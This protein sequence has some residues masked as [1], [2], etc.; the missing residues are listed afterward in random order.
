M[1]IPMLAGRD[2]DD[3]DS[4][5]RAGRRHQPQDREETL[6][7]RDPIGRQIIFGTENGIGFAAEVIGVVGDVRSQFSLSQ[8]TEDRILPAMAAAHRRSSLV[9]VRTSMKPE[10]D[11]EHRPR[12]AQ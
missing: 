7:Q 6:R 2:F 3:R 9:A 4:A 12:R 10:C 5:D 1:G 11:R 8:T